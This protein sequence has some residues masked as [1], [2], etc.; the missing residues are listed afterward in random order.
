MPPA[1][2]DWPCLKDAVDAQDHG[3]SK[4]CGDNLDLQGEIQM[5]VRALFLEGQCATDTNFPASVARPVARAVG[6]GAFA[7]TP[8]QA[9]GPEHIEGEEWRDV[10]MAS[11]VVAC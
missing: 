1:A 4:L 10:V 6:A 9:G 3:K 7:S 5:M 8:R 2:L 11:P